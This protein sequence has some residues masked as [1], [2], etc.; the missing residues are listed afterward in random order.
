MTPD[1]NLRVLRQQARAAR[2]D[3]IADTIGHVPTT[4]A[5]ERLPRVQ[6]MLAGLDEALELPRSDRKAERPEN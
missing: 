3:H 4:P 2:R 1:D 5:G 6:R